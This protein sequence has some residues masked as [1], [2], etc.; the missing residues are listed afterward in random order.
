MLRDGAPELAVSLL[1]V[2]PG[3]VAR[4]LRDRDLDLVIARTVASTRRRSTARRCG[5]R[6][7]SCACPPGT[8]SPAPDAVASPS[9]TASGC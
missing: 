2:R 8:G 5:R 7:P 3:D 4:L 9:S 1:E 6:R